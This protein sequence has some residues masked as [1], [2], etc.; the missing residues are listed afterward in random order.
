MRDIPLL[1]RL[2][3]GCLCCSPWLLLWEG[4]PSDCPDKYGNS[5][6]I[7]CIN[8]SDLYIHFIYHSAGPE[9]RGKGSPSSTTTTTNPFPSSTHCANRPRA[10]AS[11]SPAN[12]VEEL[13]KREE[14]AGRGSMKTLESN[15]GAET[16]NWHKQQAGAQG[17]G[18]QV[19]RHKGP[20]RCSGQTATIQHM[21]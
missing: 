5:V 6:F 15:T 14:G 2:A 7:G 19:K 13:R 1:A 8:I 20:G 12:G 10:P 4:F 3:H 21:P 11:S 18:G 9:G 16:V 17:G